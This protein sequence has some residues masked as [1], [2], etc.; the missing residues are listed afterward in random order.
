MIYRSFRAVDKR[1][2]AGSH[3]GASTGDKALNVVE[4]GF[5]PAKSSVSVIAERVSRL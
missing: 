1:K 3:F 4:E 5:G 2:R